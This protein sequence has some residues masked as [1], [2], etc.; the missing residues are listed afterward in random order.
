VVPEADETVSQVAVP[1]LA[2]KLV[3]GL[4]LTAIDCDGGDEPPVVAENE[5][6]V[7]LNVKVGAVELFTVN[8]TAT[9]RERPLPVTV[10]VPL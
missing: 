5:S 7:G 4:A 3:L 8:V 9:V 10:M 6:D 1:P 2:V